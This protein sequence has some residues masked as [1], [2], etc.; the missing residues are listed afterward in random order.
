L[1]LVKTSASQSS[2]KDLEILLSYHAKK[3]RKSWYSS[4]FAWSLALKNHVK[5][6]PVNLLVCIL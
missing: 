4:V 6:K 2:L 5:I 3:D 1:E